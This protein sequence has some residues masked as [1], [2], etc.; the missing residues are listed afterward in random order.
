MFFPW[1]LRLFPF[2]FPIILLL[3]AFVFVLFPLSQ[4]EIILN[5]RTAQSSPTIS[6]SQGFRI[7]RTKPIIVPL[8]PSTF[9]VAESMVISLDSLCARSSIC[10][11]DYLLFVLYINKYY[12]ILVLCDQMDLETENRIAKILLEEAAELRRRADKE[13]VHVYLQKPGVRGRPNSRFLTATVLGVQ[14]G[15]FFNLL[16]LFF[17]CSF[18]FFCIHIIFLVLVFSTLF[19]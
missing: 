5:P 3:P 15:L 18:F 13:G 14:Q 7:L 4:I 8:L 19:L 6:Q 9:Y 17:S 1:A 12:L 2:F 16:S 11:L 10:L